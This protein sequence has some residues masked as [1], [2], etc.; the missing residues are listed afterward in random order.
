VLEK[1]GPG[2]TFDPVPREQLFSKEERNTRAV[3]LALNPLLGRTTK[4]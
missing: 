3:R 4:T 1:V 2:G